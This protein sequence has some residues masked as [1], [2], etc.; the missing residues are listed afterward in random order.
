M[1]GGTRI[2]QSLLGVD[3]C[4][5]AVFVVALAAVAFPEARIRCVRCTKRCY[6]AAQDPI[7]VET[8]ARKSNCCEGVR[9]VFQSTTLAFQ[10]G[11]T[12]HFPGHLN[13]GLDKLRS[14]A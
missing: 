5:C 3:L 13:F 7:T 11:L 9:Y 6:F 2:P 14:Q 8:A 10:E 1:R 4:L 12:I